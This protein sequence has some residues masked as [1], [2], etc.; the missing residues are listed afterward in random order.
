MNMPSLLA[1]SWGG[2]RGAGDTRLG[3]EAMNEEI[4]IVRVL[5]E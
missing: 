1:L 4:G 5:A 2:T 3:L